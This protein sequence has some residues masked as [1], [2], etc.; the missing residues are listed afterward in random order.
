MSSGRVFKARYLLF[1]KFRG[2]TM[3]KRSNPFQQLV[4]LLHERLDDSWS[5]TESKMFQDSLTGEER[6]V[7]IVLES[8]VGTYKVIVSIECRDHKRKADVSWIESMVQKHHSLPTSK[9]VLWSAS[10]FSKAALK[11]AEILK[12]DTHSGGSIESINWAILANQLKSGSVKLLNTDL[13]FFIDVDTPQGIKKRLENED[14]D[15]L[16]KEIESGN[17]FR[18]SILKDF[19]ANNAD[20]ASVLLDHATVDKSD[21]WMAYTHPVECVVQDENQE[22]YKPFRIGFG[23]KAIVEETRL[24]TKSVLYE[25]KVSTLAVGQLKNRTFELFVEEKKEENPNVISKI[26]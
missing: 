14:I 16:F 10:G 13:A 21:F 19:I 1:F 12:T 18:I 15:Y 17:T 26:S 22:W 8:S 6:E 23:V 20:V 2:T 5:V 3:P 7:D 11:K 9:L 25:D 4:R 24:N